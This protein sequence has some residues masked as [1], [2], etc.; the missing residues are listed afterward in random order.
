VCRPTLLRPKTY[1]FKPPVNYIVVV[2]LPVLLPSFF[3]YLI[4][5]F[6]A[7][8]YASQRR[9]AHLRVGELA[10]KEGRLGRV[11]IV[12]A[13]RIEE[14]AE[15]AGIMDVGGHGGEGTGRV[16]E[17]SATAATKN[18]KETT[19]S[20]SDVY[21]SFSSL[22]LPNMRAGGDGADGG[23]SR[24]RIGTDPVFSSAQLRMI[25]NFNDG[26][27]SKLRRHFAFFPNVSPVIP[28]PPDFRSLSS[29]TRLEIVETVYPDMSPRLNRCITRMGRLSVEAPS[30][31][32]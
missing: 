21:S 2:F 27:L 10:S 6:I 12:I 9:I 31:F 17:G 4:L 3:T 13:Q 5:R 29:R 11:G 20:A 32:P 1:P 25:D 15:E 22:D 7:Q 16:Q 24:R 26:H 30:G 28:D 8:S 18:D 19:R 14:A 23:G